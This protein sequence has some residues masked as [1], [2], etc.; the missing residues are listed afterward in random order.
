MSA[1]PKDPS[2]TVYAPVARLH[3]GRYEYGSGLVSVRH[4]RLNYTDTCGRQLV[5]VYLRDIQNMSVEAAYVDT[6]GNYVIPCYC[7]PCAGCPDGMLNITAKG[8]GGT[9]DVHIGI[10]MPDSQEFLD[11]LN[12]EIS[13]QSGFANTE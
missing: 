6:Q 3:V 7:C 9:T 10:A 2:V 1:R 8:D 5:N 13:R 11:K 12:A 4:D